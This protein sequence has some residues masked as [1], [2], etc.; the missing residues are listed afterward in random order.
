M[1]TAGFKIETRRYKM[2]YINSL[3]VLLIVLGT[4]GGASAPARALRPVEA[5]D[6]NGSLLFV[7]NVGQFHPDAR[8]QVRGAGATLWLAEDALWITLAAPPD[9]GQTRPTHG[10]H[11]WLSFPG[12]NP[13]PRLEP[14]DR[15]DVAVNYYLGNDPARWHTNVPVWGGV[16]Y[17]DLYPGV[18]LEIAGADG[19]F[20]WRLVPRDPAS[21]RASSFALQV[22]GARNVSVKG[23]LLRLETTVGDLSLPLVEWEGVS[24]PRVTALPGGTFVVAAPFV[25]G[26]ASPLASQAA[27]DALLLGTYV[28]GSADDRIDG[29]AADDSGA[30]YITGA[31]FSTNFPTEGPGATSS[32]S[33]N[34]D[35][36]VAKL[37]KPA[38][39]FRPV[40]ST[41]LGG[42]YDSDAYDDFFTEW[43][44]DIAVEDGNA[45]VAGSTWSDDFPTT[46]GAYDTT[47]NGPA[48]SPDASPDRPGYDGFVVKLDSSGNLAYATY[49]GGSGYDFPGGGRG[50]GDDEARG[51]AVRN[52]VIYVTGYTKSSDFPTT[53]G[54]YDRTYADVDIGLND[55]VFIAKLNP[56]G[57][58]AADLLYST[59]VGKGLS[60]IGNDI[61][62]D[63]AG[64]VYVTGYAH[65]N[66]YDPDMNSDFPT[67]PGAFDRELKG[68]DWDAFLIRMNPAGNGSA[69]LLYATFLGTGNGWDYGHAVAVDGTGHAYVVGST[70]SPDFPT[71]SGAF[72]TT[73]GSDGNCNYTPALGAADDVFVAELNP[74][75]GGTS[76]LLYGTF[77]G[78]GYID[79][80]VVDW[81]DIALDDDGDVYVTGVTFSDDFPVTADAYA[82]SISG[83]IDAFV[84]RLR[85]QGKGQDDLIYST[86]LGGM[87][88]D[89]GLGIALEAKGIVW[90]AGRT[91][92]T[93]FPTTGGVFSRFH[94]GGDDGFVVKMQVPPPR[95][96]LSPSTKTVAPQQATAGEVVTFTV[97]LVNG[98][99]LEAAASFTD[100]LP[101]A[102]QLHG[103]PTASTSPSPTVNG[104]TITWNGTIA[105]SDTVTI[106]YATLLT[107]TT[108]LTPTAVNEAYIADGMG[109]VYLRRAFVNG[110][111]VYLP[112]VL[113]GG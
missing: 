16:R 46:T 25:A 66:K 28:G 60:E 4:L 34:C 30:V 45:Y 108:A 113:R 110:Y 96:D 38:A 23:N 69:D 103:T 88:W 49:L 105:V 58:G 98:G 26:D 94:N 104:R 56:A 82:D 93:D 107:S 55:D 72:D 83:S 44:L 39:L 54:A 80:E 100:T 62:V 77:L 6:D 7:E 99:E 51:I 70:A 102:L 8:F 48:V 15:Q 71:T 9:E 11:L 65:G 35:A 33:G 12:A 63:S 29:V 89:Y 43:G 47:F 41:Y 81:A 13:H 37:S 2:R 52:G 17:A 76:D 74:A 32:L 57:N 64:I 97:R 67:T 86:Y 91:D 1:W 109:N 90:V 79:G 59:F 50:G 20:A 68:D 18:D 61:A 36:F 112:L 5:G 101:A 31:T 42:S 27:A 24:F 75:G 95:P 78:G 19:R 85:L 53:A 111:R 22:E 84:A 73:C 14:F 3:V 40:Y 106:T 87:G 10:V 21:A 92:S